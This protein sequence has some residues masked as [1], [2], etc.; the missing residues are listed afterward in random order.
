MVRD[1]DMIRSI[2]LVLRTINSGPSSAHVAN[3]IC[4]ESVCGD[5]YDL[6]DH[7]MLVYKHI[8][9]MVQAGLVSGI[10][11]GTAGNRYDYYELELTWAGHD[12]IDSVVN[13]SVWKQVK[14]VIS[15]SSLKAA[16]FSVWARIASDVVGRSLGLN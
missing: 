9:L 3:Q 15:D 7:R 8:V 1:M 14:N 4:G 11:T 10:E 16:A 13:D 5:E 2:M 12:F 6:P